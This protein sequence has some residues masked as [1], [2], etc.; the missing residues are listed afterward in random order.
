[1]HKNIIAHLGTES[2]KRIKIGIG[3]SD[4]IP[5]IDW[6]LQKFSTEEFVEI[7]IA[8]SKAVQAIDEFILEN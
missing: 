4:I 1:M 6:V 5:V 8:K 2:Y 3:R 7:E